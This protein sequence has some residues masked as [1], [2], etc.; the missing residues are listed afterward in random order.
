MFKNVVGAMWNSGLWSASY[1]IA[2]VA[3]YLFRGSAYTQSSSK[4]HLQRHFLAGASSGVS[5]P[6]KMNSAA[7]TLRP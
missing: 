2:S 3:K 4:P 5:M 1:F 6:T 7:R